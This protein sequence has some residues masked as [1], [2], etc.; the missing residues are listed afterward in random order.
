MEEQNRDYIF[1]FTSQIED[2]LSNLRLGGAENAIVDLVERIATIGNI[3]V[4]NWNELSEAEA[5]QVRETLKTS[6]EVFV[7]GNLDEAKSASNNLQGALKNLEEAF[8]EKKLLL[9][10]EASFTKTT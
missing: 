8:R 5:F 6:V 4:L 10:K 3:A 2:E 9:D 1:A 7:L